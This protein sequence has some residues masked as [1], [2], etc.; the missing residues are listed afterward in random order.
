MKNGEALNREMGEGM[1][2]CWNGAWRVIDDYAANVLDDFQRMAAV[3]GRHL[4]PV[5][6]GLPSDNVTPVAVYQSVR[7]ATTP[8][9]FLESVPQGQHLGDYTIVGCRMSARFTVR[10][11]R[12][13]LKPRLGRV[14]IAEGMA[15]EHL[16]AFLQSTTPLQQP[17]RAPFLGGAIGYVGFE[18]VCLIE[19]TVSRHSVNKLDWPEIDLVAFDEVIVFDHARQLVYLVALAEFNGSENVAAAHR[20]AYERAGRLIRHLQKPI[21]PLTK[22][23]GVDGKISSNMTRD[24]YE[25]MIETGKRYITSGDVFQIV[26]SQRFSVGFSGDSFDFYR[27]L[28]RMNPSPYMFHLELSDGRVLTGASPEVMVKVSGDVVHIRP[29]AGTR[30]RS[31]DAVEDERL[32]QELAADPKERAEHSMLVDLARN[33][34]G[35]VTV[36]GSVVVSGVM[37]VEKYSTVQHLVSDV[38]GRLHEAITPFRAFLTCLPAGTLSGAPKIRACQLLVELEPCARGPYGGAVGWFTSYGLDTGIAIRTAWV[39]SGTM[40]WQAGGGVVADS[41]PAGEYEESLTK[42]RSIGNVLKHATGGTGR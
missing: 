29:I 42:A 14:E 27:H 25:R 2:S 24:V 7:R 20:D 38:S 22:L 19:P 33:D 40:Y 21:E 1:E 36:T 3:G 8:T 35:R 31:I 41:T 28:R 13:A 16:E 10:G 39:D 17:G 4:V 5:V 6:I 9:V 34:V 15:L 37:R 30:R 12:S 18:G 26:L 23:T 32:R 11:E